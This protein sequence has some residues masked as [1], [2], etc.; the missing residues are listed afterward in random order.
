MDVVWGLSREISIDFSER[1][2]DVNVWSHFTFH[3]LL[4]Q[5]RSCAQE[6]FALE[7][8]PSYGEYPIG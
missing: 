5:V 3:F 7:I 6:S 8:L 1:P 4:R 2:P